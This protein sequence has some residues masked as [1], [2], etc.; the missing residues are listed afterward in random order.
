MFLSLG[1]LGTIQNES[2]AIVGWK[3]VYFMEA[4]TETQ[5]HRAVLGVGNAGWLSLRQPLCLKDC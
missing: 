2:L 3:V 4:A 5:G 1:V